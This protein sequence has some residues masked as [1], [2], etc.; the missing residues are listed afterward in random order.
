[1]LRHGVLLLQGL[2][3]EVV[4]QGVNELDE[5]LILVVVKDRGVAQKYDQLAD[6]RD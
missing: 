2:Q 4:V 5:F 6:L 3:V 1:M